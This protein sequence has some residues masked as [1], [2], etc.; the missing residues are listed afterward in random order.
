[1]DEIRLGVVDVLDLRLQGDFFRYTSQKIHEQ[2]QLLT[3]VQR[4]LEEKRKEVAQAD[5][6]VKSLEQLRVR[7]WEKHRQQENREGQKLIDEVGQRKYY[8]KKKK[9]RTE[10]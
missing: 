8:E 10:N 2:V 6:E 3:T 4:Q 5:Q 7:L 9:T 1:M